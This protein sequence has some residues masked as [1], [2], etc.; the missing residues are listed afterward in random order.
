VVTEIADNGPGIPSEIQA[1]IVDAFFT[2]KAPGHGTGLGLGISYNIVVYKHIVATSKS[3][4]SR[5]RPS[6]RSGYRSILAQNKR[7]LIQFMKHEGSD[8][9]TKLKV[10][11]AKTR[12]DT[13][14]SRRRRF[15]EEHNIPYAWIDVDE[16]PEALAL[17]KSVNNGQRTTPTIFFE[18]GSIQCESTNEQL[19]QPL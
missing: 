8:M 10:Y 1:R 7:Q 4:Q 17:I 19:A 2:T 15:L 12:P 5:A 6:F 18:D 3:F 9:D 14:R 16:D 11:G 13:L